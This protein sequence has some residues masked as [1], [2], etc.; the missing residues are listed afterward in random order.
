[1]SDLERHHNA[2]VPPAINRGESA[3]PQPLVSV[4]IPSYNAARTIGRAV[5]SVLQQDYGRFEVIV[6]DDGST[7]ST[8][9]V[10]RQVGDPRITFQPAEKNG[11]AAAARNRGIRSA[12]GAYVAFLDADDLWLK[13]KLSFQVRM[14]ETSPKASMATCD[15][16]FYDGS[17]K[18]RGRFYERRAPAAGENAWRVLLAYNFVQ[19]STVLARRVDL[20]E[21]GGFS[22]SLPTG[23]D[24]DLWIRLASRG[25]VV[26]AS[27]TLVHVYDEP[28]SLAKRYQE[29]EGFLLLSIVRTQLLQQQQRL[30]A[31]EVRSVWGQRLF[32]V[33]ANL[34][35]NKYYGRSAPLFWRSGRLGHRPIKSVINVTRAAVNGILTGGDSLTLNAWREGLI[36]G[37]LPVS[38]PAGSKHGLEYE[39][40]GQC[41]LRN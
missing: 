7:D 29:R 3:M 41:G 4:V 27:G 20:E 28:A 19:T 17:G 10:V 6:A 36:K 1:M 39:E 26:I 13:S 31:E 16:L 21:L 15:C 33:A 24:Q 37:D 25:E 34:Y 40:G 8:E 14:M 35:H 2:G 23:E 11:G 38:K 22:E 32:D 18:P 5:Q 9:K 30:S 12:S